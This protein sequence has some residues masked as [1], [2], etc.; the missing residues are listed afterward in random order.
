LIIEELETGKRRFVSSRQ[1]QF[2]PLE[3][4]AI[5][6]DDGESVELAQV[7][8]NMLEQYEDRQPVAPTASAKELFEYFADVLPNYDPERV[9]P[10]DVKKVI[11]WFNSLHSSGLLTASD[12]EE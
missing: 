5:Y 7:F 4:I 12:E 1:H 2:T 11:K 10:G 8:R 6:T 9:Y 3:S